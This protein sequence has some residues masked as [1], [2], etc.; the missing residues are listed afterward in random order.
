MRLTEIL[1]LAAALFAVACSQ[2]DNGVGDLKRLV[3][4]FI[5]NVPIPDSIES[6]LALAGVDLDQLGGELV[7]SIPDLSM[8]V[9]LLPASTAKL[10]G[11]LPIVKYIE[12][13]TLM[14][15]IAPIISGT[16]VTDLAA[17]SAEGD[18]D[19]GRFVDDGEFIPYGI[20]MVQAM[21]V[22]DANVASR[23]VCIIDTG[24]DVTHFDL[25]GNDVVSG[26]DDIGAGQWFEDGNSHGTHVGGIIAAV[27][28]NAGGVLGVV[29]NA[30][31]N[32][33]IVKYLDD[34]GSSTFGST[35]I[36][37]A[38]EC[39]NAGANVISMSFG[40]T[41]GP[42]V[43]GFTQFEN[44]AFQQFYDNGILLVAAAGNDGT[45]AFNWPASYDSVISVGAIDESKS[46][47]SFSQRNSGVE[48]VAPGVGVWS[49]V[50]NNSFELKDGTSMA[51]PHVSAVA[52]LIWSLY[53]NESAQR[54]RE[55]LA[56]TAEDLGPSG[57]DPAYGFGL[58]QAASALQCLESGDCSGG[59]MP[60]SPPTSDPPFVDC[61]DDP[62]GWVDSDG[63]GCDDFYNTQSNCFSFGDSFAN[64]GKTANDACCTCGGGQPGG[65]ECVDDPPNWVDSVGD[66]CD[67][68]SEGNN[69]QVYAGEIGTDGKTPLQACCVCRGVLS[70]AGALSKETNGDGRGDTTTSGEVEGFLPAKLFSL[71]FLYVGVATV[72]M[73]TV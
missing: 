25:P 19:G 47:A 62:V 64:G 13:D 26:A 20:D 7:F 46:I 14:Q 41:E 31:L 11:D 24:F 45:T 54:I 18:V 6:L 29:S 15:L 44:D 36:A 39:V 48:L 66:G 50:P 42:G 52:A 57:W 23:N 67:W 38:Q 63:D 43:Q 72:A 2:E 49:T 9:A 55:V 53:P 8:L 17:A 65:D 32:L 71:I 21:D 16:A 10:L 61:I 1:L 37:A 73:H 12:E 70:S 3:V 59:T 56:A 60:T 27:G 40:R 34:E 22:S 33:F 4:R 30:R 28:G 58:V 68:Y 5:S 51:C 69:C 35:A